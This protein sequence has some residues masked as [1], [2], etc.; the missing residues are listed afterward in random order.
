MTQ[1]KSCF[2]IRLLALEQTFHD[3]KFEGTSLEKIAKEFA[4]DYIEQLVIL[5]HTWQLQDGDQV[6]CLQA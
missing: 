3:S 5:L 4:L 6:G 1:L 2:S